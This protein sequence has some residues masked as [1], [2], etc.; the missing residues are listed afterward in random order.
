MSKDLRQFL[1]AARELGPDF[2][3]EVKKPLKPKFEPC[4]I[5][6]KLAKEGRFPVIYCPQIEGSKLP[7]VTDLF[8]SY[9]MLGLALDVD[10]RQMGKAEII[11]EYRKREADTK[12]PQMIPASEAPVKEVVLQGKDVDLSLLPIIFHQEG[13][14]GK[15]INIGSMICKDPDTGIPNVA[16][17]RHEVK[18]KDILGGMFVPVHHAAYIA[19]RYAELGKPMEVVIIIGHHPAITIGACSTGDIND[20][21]L[22][23]IGGLLG[24]PLQVTPAETVDIPVPARAEIAIEG[25]IDPRN[26]GTDGPFGEFTHYYGPETSCYIIKVTAITMRRDA[27]YHDLDNA[28][29]EHNF[30]SLLPNESHTFDVIKRA[31]PTVQA[32]HLPWTGL[33]EFHMYA[34][35]KKRLQGEG[36]FAGLAAITA[37]AEAKLA[38]VVDEDVDVYD[39]EDVL[40]AITTRVQADQDVTIIPWVSGADLDP[41]CYDETRIKRGAMTTKMIIDATKPV[42]APF[43]PRITPPKA[44]WDSMKLDDYLK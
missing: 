21:E 14:S 43:A 23:L 4:I 1:E 2:Y 44:L 30:C 41:S 13:D 10:A 3:V 39:E 38:V 29:R 34:S 31:V 26:M 11:R 9:E 5:Q 19:R 7:L 17:Y 20:N 15:Y 6:E 27:I 28:H 25:V 40:W 22:E 12:P 37:N 33:C 18:G 42:G 36:K 32:V 35:I 24:E 8:G 16:V